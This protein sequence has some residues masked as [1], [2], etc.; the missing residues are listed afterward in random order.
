MNFRQMRLI[1]SAVDRVIVCV[2]LVWL[3]ILA[4][5]LVVSSTRYIVGDHSCKIQKI[6]DLC[7]EGL[8]KAQ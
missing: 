4:T 6:L 7:E 2:I 3:L 5:Q 1:L 8:G